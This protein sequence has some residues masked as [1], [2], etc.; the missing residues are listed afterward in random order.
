MKKSEELFIQEIFDQVT[1]KNLFPKG[2]QKN[3]SNVLDSMPNAKK[4][5]LSLAAKDPVGN[6]TNDIQKLRQL[7]YKSIEMI[8]ESE[9]EK[10]SVRFKKDKISQYQGKFDKELKEQLKGVID[11]VAVD[12]KLG[13]KGVNDALLDQVQNIRGSV[14][15]ESKP[16][17]IAK[18]DLHVYDKYLND[19]FK[20]KPTEE[21]KLDSNAN[22]DKSILARAARVITQAIFFPITALVNYVAKGVTYPTKQA[23][24]LYL[25]KYK[26]E[27]VADVGDG[28]SKKALSTELGKLTDKQKKMFDNLDKKLQKLYQYPQL[29]SPTEKGYYEKLSSLVML[30]KKDREFTN[31]LTEDDR[32][33]IKLADKISAKCSKESDNAIA[34]YEKTKDYKEKLA[35]KINEADKA[36]DVQSHKLE[37]GNDAKYKIHKVENAQGTIVHFHGNGDNLNNYSREKLNEMYPNQNVI[38]MAYPGYSG[39]K[40]PTNKKNIESSL[41]QVYNHIKNDDKNKDLFKVPI[42]SSGISVG[43]YYATKFANDHSECTGL[44]LQNT[45]SN[46][47]QTKGFEFASGPHRVFSNEVL[48]TESVLKH[49]RPDMPV[50]ISH[51]KRDTIFDPEKNAQQN[52]N[53]SKSMYKKITIHDGGHN[54]GNFSENL[55]KMK[56]LQEKKAQSKGIIKKLPIKQDKGVSL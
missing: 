19:V 56:E 1:M 32:K 9:Y 12:V 33:I 5:L 30:Y 48:D 10:E 25:Q 3:V 52:Y 47:T 38:V 42:I 2:G 21:V 13:T 8:V 4:E 6:M 37:N 40:G 23:E 53:S 34:K 49:M 51:G 29:G 20:H 35:T 24:K 44:M 36:N 18:K 55:G 43:G 54:D 22:R 16:L 45:Y 7:G 27:L 11:N 39:T 28:A 26:N 31:S 17:P 50:V 15:L 14:G 46:T 41:D